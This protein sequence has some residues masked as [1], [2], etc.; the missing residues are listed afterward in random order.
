M[1]KTTDVEAGTNSPAVKT[2]NWITIAI[3]TVCTAAIIVIVVS[4][5]VIYTRQNNNDSKA[6]PTMTVS[7]TMSPTTSRIQQLSVT[8]TEVSFNKA[9]LIILF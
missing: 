8:T 2:T 5:S 4:L 7:P 9:I 3:S 6:S 1:I